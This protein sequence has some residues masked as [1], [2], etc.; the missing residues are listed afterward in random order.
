MGQGKGDVAEDHDEDAQGQH[1]MDEGRA[2]P[3]VEREEPDHFRMDPVASM[4]T[5]AP[6]MNRAFSFWPGLNLSGFGYALPSQRPQPAELGRR[7]Q[8]E[9]PNVPSQP[10]PQG[11]AREMI[12][13]TGRATPH[14][15]WMS[16]TRA[17]RPTRL[18]TWTK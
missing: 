7:P 15:V 3:P 4:T 13:G 9:A 14:H 10:F 2:G 17:R 8:V 1:V 12:R 11:P 18:S 5:M 6:A 16:A